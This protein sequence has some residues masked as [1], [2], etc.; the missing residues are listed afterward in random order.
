M[1][2]GIGL[3]VTNA[4]A[5][6]EA[7]IG[8]Q[9]EFVRTPKYRL[10]AGEEGWEGKK[11]VRR[12]AGW[13]PFVEL[14]PR[15]LLPLHHGLFP[16]HGELSH[17]TRSCCSSLWATRTWEPCRCSKPRCGASRALP[18]SSARAPSSLPRNSH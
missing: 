9:T 11:Y 7:I 1:A 17:H 15:R 14:W 18:R 4:K 2:T 3:A 10:E 6:I 8:K 5:V 16:H 12:R 13:I